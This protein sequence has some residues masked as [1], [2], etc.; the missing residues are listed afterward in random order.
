MEKRKILLIGGTGT[1]SKPISLLLSQ[2]SDNEVYV[3]NRGHKILPAP[4]I[5]L[6]GDFN[7]EA[8][9]RQIINTYTF[10]IVVNFVIYKP[11]QAQKQVELFM[12]RI[13]QYVFISTVVTYNHETAVMIDEQQPQ[14]NVYSA[15]G[16]LKQACEQ[17]FLQAYQQKGF[18]ITIVRPSQTYGEDRIPLSVK[19]KTCYSV[20]DRIKRGK[21]VIVH[22]DG[23]SCWHCTHTLDFAANFIPLL[24]QT[25][26]IGQAYQLCNPQ[27]VNWDMIYNY[28]YQKCQQPAQLCHISTDVLAMSRQYDNLSSIKGDKQYS[29]VFDVSKIKA[30]VP[31]FSNQIDIFTGIDLYFDYLQKNPQLQIP[32][33]DFDHWCDQ[34]IELQQQYMAAFAQAGL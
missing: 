2:N 32:D 1:I 19:G 28:L 14:G 16:R 26:V 15:Y 13:S 23:K 24:G 4:V 3:L 27:V 30:V 6:T 34:V 21:P 29:N 25:K 33:P 18:P 10:D 20:I 17:V 31:S 8:F 11:E 22:G 7:D 12:G 5:Q 9:M